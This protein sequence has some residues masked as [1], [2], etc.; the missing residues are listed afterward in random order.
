MSNSTQTPKVGDPSPEAISFAKRMIALKW[1]KE[2]NVETVAGMWQAGYVHAKVDQ[3]KTFESME[4]EQQI[5]TLKLLMGLVRTGYSQATLEVC[6]F[7]KDLDIPNELMDKLTDMLNS[8]SKKKFSSELF[9]KEIEKL[10]SP[11]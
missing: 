7:C 4:K 5:D 11:E 10:S 6:D 2:T 8:E 1:T 3:R 9:K